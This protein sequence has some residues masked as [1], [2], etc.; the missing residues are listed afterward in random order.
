MHEKKINW[1]Q[2]DDRLLAIVPGDFDRMG[3]ELC[4]CVYSLN[5]GFEFNFE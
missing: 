2:S 1:A 3:D 4:T 5:I